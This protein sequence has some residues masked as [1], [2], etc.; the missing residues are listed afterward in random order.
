MHVTIRRTTHLH[1]SN[2]V[3]CIVYR[4]EQHPRFLGLLDAELEIYLR[5]TGA[6]CGLS[7]LGLSD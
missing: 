6:G 5:S 7:L 3:S 4:L 1:L 2:Y